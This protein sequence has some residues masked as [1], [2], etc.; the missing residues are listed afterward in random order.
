MYGRY[1]SERLSCIANAHQLFDEFSG[2]AI[3]WIYDLGHAYFLT[4]DGVTLNLGESGFSDFP[5]FI[6]DELHGILEEKK[7]YLMKKSDG[8]VW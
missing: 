1:M 7:G 3:I 5:S 2:G 6:K 4:P 8:F